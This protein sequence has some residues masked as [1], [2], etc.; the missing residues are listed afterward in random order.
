MLYIDV[1]NAMDSAF[2]NTYNFELNNEYL[3]DSVRLWI[4]NTEQAI[5]DIK[6]NRRR[7]V[8]SIVWEW[9]MDFARQRCEE[10]HYPLLNNYTPSS[11]QLKKYLAEYGYTPETLFAELN[12]HYSE[13]RKDW[14]K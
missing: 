3:V 11:A 4:D 8:H 5:S 13:L 2:L 1:K 14:L 9:F 12:E 6:S 7:K 10:E